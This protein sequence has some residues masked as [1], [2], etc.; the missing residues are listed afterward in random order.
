MLDNP[1]D[2]IKMIYI[3]E[4]EQLCALKPTP[5]GRLERTLL[6][7]SVLKVGHCADGRGLFDVARIYVAVGVQIVDGHV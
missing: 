7:Q 5:Y 4:I 1:V 2:R 6:E 3:Y